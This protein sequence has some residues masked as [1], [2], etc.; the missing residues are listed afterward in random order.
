[1]EI[2]EIKLGNEMAASANGTIS[3]VTQIQNTLCGELQKGALR[4]TAVD[5][6][7]SNKIQQYES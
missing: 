2:M 5:D 7:M 4:S 6:T 3:W 1:M